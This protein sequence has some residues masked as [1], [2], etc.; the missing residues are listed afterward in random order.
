MAVEEKGLGT[1]TETTHPTLWQAV[2]TLKLRAILM[3]EFTITE[4]S[5]I[6]MASFFTSAILGA[7]RQALFNA[8]FGI[9]MEANAY[10]AAFR[11]PDTLF[12]LIAGGTLS[13]A[14]IPVLLGTRRSEGDAAGARLVSLVLTTLLVTMTL[15]I[16]VL[17]IFTPLFVRYLLA[18]GF[19]AETAQLTVTLTRIKL[20]QPLILSMGSVATAVLNSR[21]RFLLPALSITTYNLTL[22]G[23]ILAA[24]A[25]PPLGVYGPTIGTVVGAALQVLIL[26]PGF[27]ALRHQAWFTWDP[28]D[29]HL[30]AVVRL[31]IPNGLSAMV[32]YTGTIVDTAFASLTAQM[33]TLPA[34]YNASLLA[35]LPVT[36][37]GYAVGL[38]AFPRLA[39]RAEA[40]AWPQL[41]RLLRQVLGVVCSLSLL[42]I[43]VIYA[44]GRFTIRTL[45]ERGEFTAAAGDATYAALL[46][47]SLGLP[48]HIATE[49]MSRG[50][51]ALRDT[52]TPLFT[53]IGQ[54][55]SRATLMAFFVPRIGLYAIPVAF[56]TS[57]ILET[58]A[59][60]IV[61]TIKLRRRLAESSG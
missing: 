8:Q 5:V 54:L 50:L 18:P 13:N 26:W 42:A 57:S 22:I 43:L 33:V 31:L 27:A 32:N 29:F 30:R 37:L 40:Q 1:N 10:Y 53:N 25:Y 28:T 56:V 35:N 19:D 51:I 60:G 55:I 24:R 4:A 21:N 48:S 47:Y 58:I 14:M 45:F 20:L 6:L 49:I 15:I 39:D 11:L 34:I 38:A 52:R 44:L 23:G 7:L 16:V 36:L 17:A 41:V 3:H 46:L 61:L 59:L 12:T 9:S 2:R